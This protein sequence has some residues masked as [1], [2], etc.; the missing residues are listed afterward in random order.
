MTN[1]KKLENEYRAGRISRREFLQATSVMGLAITAPS[2]FT[3]AQAA[4]KKR[5]AFKSRIGPWLHHGL[6]G[7]RQLGKQLHPVSSLFDSQ[8]SDRASA[9]WGPGA[10]TGG[11]LGTFRG[12]KDVDLQAAQGR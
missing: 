12:C 3:T 10:G 9:Q 7:S 5:R 2:I 8:S 6:P 4:P 11:E 1:L